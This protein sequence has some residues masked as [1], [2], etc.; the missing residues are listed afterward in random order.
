RIVLQH[1]ARERDLDARRRLSLPHGSRLGLGPRSARRRSVDPA[2]YQYHGTVTARD[3]RIDPLH[4]QH[5]AVEAHNF[6]VVGTG[7]I[8][9]RTQISLALDAALE[10]H[11]LHLRIVVAEH[12]DAARR[13]GLNRIGLRAALAL[14][15]LFGTGAILLKMIR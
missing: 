12:S 14:G 4:Q 6:A 1:V 10:V 7:R 9:A 5:P 15:V 3:L 13:G 2:T 11:V 8:P